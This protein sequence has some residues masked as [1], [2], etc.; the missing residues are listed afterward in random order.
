LPGQDFPAFRF[1]FQIHVFPLF[2][3]SMPTTLLMTLDCADRVGLLARI[4]GF[5]AS[6]KGNF[7]EVHQYT[8]PINGWF[9]ARF[10]FEVPEGTTLE[11]VRRDFGPTAVELNASWNI[12]DQGRPLRTV[13]LVSREDHCLADMLWRW[14]SKEMNIEVPLVISNHDTLRTQVEKEGLPFLHI[15][16][17]AD[18]TGKEAAFR[19]IS[20]AICDVSGELSILCRYMQIMPDWFC[21]EHH[22]RVINIH[23]SLLPA[24]AGADPYRKAYDRG[25][26]LIGATCHY[27]T[28][29]LDAGPIIHQQMI[30]VEHYHTPAD[31]R[32]LGRDCERLTLARGVRLH[33]EDRVV[34]HGSRAIVFGD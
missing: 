19:R 2:L 6:Q 18:P 1:A 28:A 8:D 27:A 15:P 10:A 16:V 4:T 29:E 17:P 34:V 23:H 13:L 32:R 33:V 30:P 31:M 12:R 22:N 5:V 14:R 3:H 9:F 21:E 25:V 24:F 26:K 20:D 11:S 7:T